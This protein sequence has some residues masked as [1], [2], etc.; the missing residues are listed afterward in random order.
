MIFHSHK[1]KG[2]RDVPTKIFCKSLNFGNFPKSLA[3]FTTLMSG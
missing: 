3:K 2:T 1:I